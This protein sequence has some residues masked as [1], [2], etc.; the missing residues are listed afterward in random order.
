MQLE[1]SDECD[2]FEHLKL[3]PMDRIVQMKYSCIVESPKKRFF[4]FEI[5]EVLLSRYFIYWTN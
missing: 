2:S 1:V 3:L 4:H 5:Y